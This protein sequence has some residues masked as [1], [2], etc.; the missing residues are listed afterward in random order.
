MA[1]KSLL[2]NDGL[3]IGTDIQ[4]DC[5]GQQDGTRPNVAVIALQILKILIMRVQLDVT[6]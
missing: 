2:V 5:S 3:L 4:K 1:A 6:I